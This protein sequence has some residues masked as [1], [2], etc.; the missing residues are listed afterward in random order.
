[1]A[2]IETVMENMNSFYNQITTIESSLQPLTNFNSDKESINN[3]NEIYSS[4]NSLESSKLRITLAYSLGSLLFISN[5]LTNNNSNINEDL[6][7]IKQYVDKIK[8]IENNNN[9]NT[10]KGPLTNVNIAATKRIL[11]HT[12]ASNNIQQQQHQKDDHRNIK[13][14]SNNNSNITSDKNVEFSDNNNS[15]SKNKKQKISKK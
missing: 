2:K 8:N 3:N 14:N 1:M 4:L 13:I 10:N 9:N 12:L 6:K 7:K 11:K 5:Q 15:N